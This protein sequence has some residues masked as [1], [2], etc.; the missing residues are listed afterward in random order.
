[1]DHGYDIAEIAESVGHDRCLTALKCKILFARVRLDRNY[2]NTLTLFNLL[3]S[4]GAQKPDF[5][6]RPVVENFHKFNLK[7]NLRDSLLTNFSG[8]MGWC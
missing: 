7:D 4:R 1:M 2:D 6:Y 3:L 8:S 5:S